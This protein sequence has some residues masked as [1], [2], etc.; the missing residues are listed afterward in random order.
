MQSFLEHT[1]FLNQVSRITARKDHLY[2]RIASSHFLEDLPT[3]LFRHD[4]VQDEQTD[5]VAVLPE[6]LQGIFPIHSLDD[7]IPELLHYSESRTITR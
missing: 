7:G 2:V 1:F 3:A 4:D 6:L 5:P